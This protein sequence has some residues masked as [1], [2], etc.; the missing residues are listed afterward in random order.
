[1]LSTS[2][3]QPFS[4]FAEGDQT[5]KLRHPLGILG[6]GD[7][8]WRRHL[9]DYSVFSYRILGIQGDSL[10]L[11]NLSLGVFTIDDAVSVASAMQLG[12]VARREQL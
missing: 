10:R 9:T 4:A 8:D 5:A 3:P 7:A 2:K 1:M 6:D 11:D 12:V